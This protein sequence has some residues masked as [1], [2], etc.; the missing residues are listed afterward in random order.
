M[1]LGYVCRSL[2]GRG[3]G[4]LGIFGIWKGL[5]LAVE[6]LLYVGRERPIEIIGDVGD[7]EEV[8]SAE[9]AL[10]TGPVRHQL[11]ERLAG[12]ADDDFLA[13]G[14][15]VNQFRKLRLRRSDVDDGFHGSFRLCV[16]SRSGTAPCRWLR[17]PG[18]RGGRRASR[19]RPPA[20]ASGSR[21]WRR[22]G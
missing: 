21:P 6:I 3:I 14:G 1:S 17:R 8:L 16:T 5:P 2:N 12:L 18:L 15:P 9:A 22:G 4:A 10:L 20:I 19:H 7:P 11:G 13:G